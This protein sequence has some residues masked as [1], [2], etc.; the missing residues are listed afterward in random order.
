[1]SVPEAIASLESLRAE[2]LAAVE[3]APDAAAL[4]EV[5]I[6][7]LGRKGPLAGI[8]STLGSLEP[9]ERRE[10]GKVANE[11]RAAIEAAVAGRREALEASEAARRLEGDRVD[12]TL[13]G[14]RP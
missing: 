9:D 14:R 3:E 8:V 1:M 2:A 13:P 6:R 11:V 12:V 5:E 10:V 4:R 7:F